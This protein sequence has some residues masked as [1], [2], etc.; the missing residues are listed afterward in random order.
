MGNLIMYDGELSVCTADINAVEQC[1]G[2]MQKY[3]LG[4]LKKLSHCCP[5]ILR[6]YEDVAV[7]VPDMDH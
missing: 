4:Y 2:Q 6:I 1:R 3:V 5:R 7:L